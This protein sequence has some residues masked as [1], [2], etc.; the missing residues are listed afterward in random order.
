VPP[1]SNFEVLG[2]R[3]VEG[4][5]TYAEVAFSKALAPSQDFRGLVSVK[6]LEG[7]KVSV[8]RNLLKIYASSG[9]WPE[10]PVIT[11]EPGVKASSGETL[12]Q[13][14]RAS[15]A[16]AYELPEARFA[17]AGVIVPTSQGSTIP[18]ETRNLN[19]LI[20]EIFQIKGNN[21]TQFLQ[22]NNLDGQKELYR[23]GKALSRTEVKLPFS[24][25]DRNAWKRTGLDLSSL[26]KEH[27]DGMFQVRLMFARRHVE[28][29]CLKDHKDFSGMT[30][31]EPA[32]VDGPDR[33]G[34]YWDYAEDYY[35][36]D[37]EGYY[38]SYNYR[39]DPCHPAFY[40]SYGDHSIIATRNILVSDIGLLAKA[41]AD[42][43]FH[44]FAT[45]LKTAMPLAGVSL[46]VQDY[47]RQVLAS[48]KTDAAG[49]LTVK[50][51]EKPSFVVAE[52]G[53]Q[54]GFLKLDEGLSLSVSQFDVGGDKPKEGLKG[55]IYGERGVWR[56]G[57]DIH[58]TFLLLDEEKRLPD[59]YPVVLEFQNPRGQLV[60][61][62]ACADSLGGFYPIKLSTKAEDPTGDWLVTVRAGGASFTKS[63]KVESI[64]PN[65]LKATVD[66][67][68]K[69]YL[70]AR[71]TRMTLEAKWLHGAP[72]PGLKADVSATFAPGTT[73]FPGFGDYIF[74]D[75]TKTL[76]SS[77]QMLWEGKLDAFSR[78]SFD[79]ELDSGANAPGKLKATLQS[80]VFEPSGVFS[81]ETFA[82][83][84]HPYESYVGIK[85]PKG[86]QTRGMLLTDTDH[87]VGLALVD[88]DGAPLDGEVKVSLYQVRWRWWWEKGEENM[89]EFA[90]SNSATR[91]STET[92]KVKDGRGQYKLRV[93]YPSWGRYFI[94]AEGPSGHTAGKIFYIDWPGWAGKARDENPGGAQ[95]LALESPKPSY[96]I[97]E[98]IAVSFPSNDKAV[99]LV[100]VEAG[101]KVLRKQ[102]VKCGPESTK[103]EIPASPEMAPNVYFH[104]SLLQ[105]HLQTM[106][107]LPIRLYGILGVMVEDPAS[108]LFPTL[109][110]KDSLAPGSEVSF[111]V[112]EANGRAMTYT[113][114]VVDEGLLGLTRFSVPS[115]WGS[116]YRKEASTLRSWDLFQYVAG[117]Y[118]GKLEN[119]L[120]IGGGDD[121]FGSG[122]RKAN[123][124]PPVVRYLGPFSLAKGEK[125]SHSFTLPEYVGAVR[126]MV[127]A[128]S[129]LSRAD[130]AGPAAFGSIEK[131]VTVRSDLMVLG[132]LPRVLS[133]GEK[134]S[135]PVTL[136]SYVEGKSSVSLK[137]EASGPVS[138][139]SGG[140]QAVE[141]DGVGDKTV[142]CAVQV[143]DSVGPARFAI[144]ARSGTA[145]AS[146][147]IEIEVRPLGRPVYKVV[148]KQVAPGASYSEAM[149]LP[150]LSGT[151]SLGLEVS[152]LPPID[153]GRRL[154]YLLVYPHG[155]IEQTTS[156][157]FPQLFLGKAVALSEAQAGAA[158]ANIKAGIA[159]LKTFQTPRG[160]FSYWPGQAEESEWG[161]N[162]AGH[163]LVLA[164][165]A[166]FTV[167]EELLEAW[168]SYQSKAAMGF[169]PRAEGE[170]S[171]D[172]MIQA[173]RLYTL[174]LAGYPE[175]G[176]MN[177]LR[178]HEDM[179]L[180]ARWRLAAAYW[181]AGQRSQAS[182]MVASL[183]SEVPGYREDEGTFGSGARD[184]AMILE[185]LNLIDP[186]SSRL[187]GLVKRVA[188]RLS[189]EGFLSTQ[190]LS[191][192]LIALLPYA[193]A[194][195]Q[196][197]S[198]Q[199]SY[200][201]GGAESSAV[202]T[203]A[204]SQIALE[205]PRGGKAAL[206]FRNRSSDPL[207]VKFIAKGVP[208]AE[209]E[210]SFDKGLDFSI[211]YATA[212][213]RS[214]RPEEAGEGEDFFAYLKVSNRSGEKLAN[215]AL[216]Y[217]VPGA[218]EIAND[219]SP[220]LQEEAP[221][222]KARNS[223]SGRAPK[224]SLDYVD[225]RDDRVLAY[226]GL[227]EGE[228]KT[229]KVRL[230]KTYSG[231]FYL[232]SS[233]VEAMYDPAIQAVEAGRWLSRK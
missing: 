206:S 208:S 172:Y 109:A 197:A 87:P 80:R 146:Q 41:G 65:R 100:V 159:R 167:Q 213:G 158:E 118:S 152:R 15:V 31:P 217:V 67:G 110:V 160:G 185:A 170:G 49:M 224:Q 29:E 181:L 77:R 60:S 78:A 148:S 151:N 225:I 179:P 26:V 74:E 39:N 156:S 54:S 189:A 18:I 198:Q 107:D 46:A 122:N 175:I 212:E 86:D 136:Y 147:N 201:S 68:K 28:Y 97:G 221:P 203:K 219:G 64:M 79:V 71:R 108:R 216:T 58:L 63:L 32:I 218:W 72:A 36:G 34:S 23:V 89:A 121:G 231:S 112:A 117:A 165:Q 104:V 7:T 135:L 226:F 43:S 171:G 126:F 123:R 214:F 37:S 138:I 33:E 143:G 14:Q 194:N 92:V 22:V 102:W 142:S 40:R 169:S 229:L 196:A 20:V 149:D 180:A 125:N 59:K 119:L 223:S 50:P 182:Q 227:E 35:D 210:T 178:E 16:F 12:V 105:P 200:G 131:E 176:A 27:P 220:L 13:F 83:D 186:S 90:S 113:V 177:R 188:G 85:L 88:R 8:D 145:V 52:F 4:D 30:F 51:G 130:A 168:R 132:T 163:F 139:A 42:G 11:V 93:N 61:R 98:K 19:G 124:F 230:I 173:Y 56:P 24:K 166:G 120:A 116:F 164:K 2:F 187:E 45:D 141:M 84:F 154:D 134:V 144:T 53:S 209:S 184:E 1:A 222:A 183:G 207:W 96:T 202:L 99:A 191:Y 155:C 10:N 174:A 233:S 47:Q 228:T 114:A 106:N 157:V 115:P 162:Y 193:G 129:G 111:Q 192:S 5:E 48:G 69:D 211:S 55:F 128:A 9:S 103:F 150:G 75:P 195:A 101:G 153:L 205:A 190:E 215:L 6:G 133:P 3:A 94:V 57:D 127:V 161:T 62:Q 73:S 70:D 66:Y 44:L 199:Y 204:F 91:V 17:G 38:S 25:D 95:M 21:M 81:S 232:P 137:V 140:S 76:S 82:V